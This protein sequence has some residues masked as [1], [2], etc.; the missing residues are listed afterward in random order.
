MSPTITSEV[1]CAEAR[2]EAVQRAEAHGHNPDR[3]TAY[4]RLQFEPVS[5]SEFRAVSPAGDGTSLLSLVLDDVE[6][7]LALE[8][9][10]HQE[11]NGSI[12]IFWRPTA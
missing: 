10:E 7:K 12:L 8:F 2:G 5:E 4:R 11:G 1:V 3:A 6:A 9:I